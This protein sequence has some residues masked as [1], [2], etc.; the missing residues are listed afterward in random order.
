M[1][2]QQVIDLMR[3]SKSEAEWNDNCRKVKEVFG[4]YPSFWWP[5]IVQSGIMKD[6]FSA[7][8]GNDQINI[9]VTWKEE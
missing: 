1:D 6:V 4:G 5:T 2:K 3:T 9:T 7:W 8:G